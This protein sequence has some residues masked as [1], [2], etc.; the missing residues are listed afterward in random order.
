MSDRTT[1]R[2]PLRAASLT[3]AASCLFGGS[4]PA[5]DIEKVVEILKRKPT[6]KRDD[7][8]ATPKRKEEAPATP[9]F[10]LR[11][12]SK[13]AG[14]P[15][16]TK[17]LVKTRY[18]T[19]EVPFAELTRVR[20]ARRLAPEIAKKIDALID[21]L[22]RNDFDER[23]E[24]MEELRKV[25]D[26]AL[27]RLRVASGSKNEEVRNRAEILV[28]EIEDLTTNGAADDE[29]GLRGLED[30]VR[31]NRMTLKGEVLA[32]T[33]EIDSRYGALTISVNDLTAIHFR[34]T[35]AMSRKVTVTPNF[36]PP[37]KW[38]DTKVDV[39]KKQDLGIQ[40]SGLTSVGD[41]N[42]NSG[43]DGNTR[44]SGNTFGGFPP[45]TLIGKL[46]KDG[47]PFKV[48]AKYR[49]KANAKGRLYLSIVAFMYSPTSTTGKYSASIKLGATR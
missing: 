10:L 31:T 18:G 43:P 9:V 38:L 33:I 26:Q 23:E 1:S 7:K 45:L 15:R 21:R 27:E 35:G 22:G 4:G 25:G 17:L 32:D 12:R 48:G 42:V 11:D 5:Q 8:A 41:W 19:L 44:Y 36:Q 24:A 28:E 20:F 30:E 2:L 49:A 34:P 47:K 46:G 3:I 40:A 37:G 29:P 6:V 13:V 16:F 39:Q 14:K